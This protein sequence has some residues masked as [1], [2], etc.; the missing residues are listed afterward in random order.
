MTLG[1]PPPSSSMRPPRTACVRLDEPPPQVSP[2]TV[3]RQRQP[4]RS[5]TDDQDLEIACGIGRSFSTYLL[6]EGVTR[7]SVPIGGESTNS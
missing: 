5:G 1:G 6:P 3:V 2:G 4:D 7:A